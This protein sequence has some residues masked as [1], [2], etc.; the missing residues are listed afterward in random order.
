MV[1]EL[2]DAA[3]GWDS[4]LE[5]HYFGHTLYMLSYHD[6]RYQTDIPLQIRFL[7]A[8]RHDYQRHRFPCRIQNPQS[9]IQGERP[10]PGFRPRQLSDL[11]PLQSQDIRPFIDL[12]S[13]RSRPASIPG[14]LPLTRMAPLC[15]RPDTAWSTGL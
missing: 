5:C 4:D 15:A 3:W 9:A 11:Q 10:L 13:K 2:P 1:V 7:D 6:E 12:N 14:L 8:R